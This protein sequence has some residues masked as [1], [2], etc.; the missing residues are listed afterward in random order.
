MLMIRLAPLL[1]RHTSDF[2]PSA[3]MLLDLAIIPYNIN[4]SALHRY[5][6]GMG[7]KLLTMLAI[8]GYKKMVD[9]D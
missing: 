6:N 5:A 2:A 9:Q 4:K 1:T 8:W 3:N 7:I